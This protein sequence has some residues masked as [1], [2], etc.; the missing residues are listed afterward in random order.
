LL[1]LVCCLF[2]EASLGLVIKLFM[3]SSQSSSIAP[4]VAVLSQPS[5]IGTWSWGGGVISDRL[6][7]QPGGMCQW[8]VGSC[9]WSPTSSANTINMTRSMPGPFH[10]ST[11]AS[12]QFTVGDSGDVAELVERNNV[13]NE[14][15]RF[16]TNAPGPGPAP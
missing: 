2:A 8:S 10:T 15:H 13:V 7:I 1:G 11:D 5:Y 9:S 3:T 12:G 16:S 14:Y 6:V 4:V